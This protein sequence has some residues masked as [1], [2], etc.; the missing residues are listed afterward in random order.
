MIFC[1][2]LDV[3]VCFLNILS[4]R[5]SKTDSKRKSYA[6]FSEHRIKLFPNRKLLAL[7]HVRLS[8]NKSLCLIEIS[9]RIYLIMSM[10]I[11]GPL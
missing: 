4:G 2:N 8:V 7:C 6:C 9:M 5:A 10:R 11:Y 3:Y 1:E